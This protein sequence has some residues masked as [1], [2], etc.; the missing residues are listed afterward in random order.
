MTT[1]LTSKFTKRE[2]AWQVHPYPCIGL[3]RFLTLG[4]PSTP[5]YQSI[6]ERLKGGETLLDLGCCFAAELRVLAHAGA[7]SS[8]LIGADLH[9]EFISCGYDLF[10]DRDSFT[11]RFIVG[12]ILTPSPSPF[13]Q[14]HHAVDMIWAGSFLHLFG[15]D[16]QIEVCIKIVA[17]MKP[18]PGGVV[19]G[20]QAGNI[21]PGEVE[22]K[23]N[24]GGRMYRHDAASFETMWRLVGEQTSTVWRVKARLEVVNDGA[25]SGDKDGKS[26]WKGDDGSRVLLFAVHRE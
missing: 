26:A 6:L 16:R 3:H 19:F 24:D 1:R 17:M 9:S 2:K 14:L 10:R 15:W 22:H 18:R 12:D 20:R 25:N 4:I 11:G 21:H 23:A 8:Q 5:S 13:D 7:P